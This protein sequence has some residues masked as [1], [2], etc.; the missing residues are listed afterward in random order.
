[1]LN[2]DRTVQRPVEKGSRLLLRVSGLKP[3]RDDRAH[4]AK[5]TRFVSLSNLVSVA[6][7]ARM[8]RAR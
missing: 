3:R 6:A 5:I 7:Y 1:M 4:C 8:H 2:R